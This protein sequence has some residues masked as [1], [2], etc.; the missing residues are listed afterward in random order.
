LLGQGLLAA[1]IARRLGISPRTV[2]KHLENIYRKLSVRDRLTAVA[3]A[4]SSGI[5][6]RRRTSRPRA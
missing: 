4:Q 3:V 1:T 5:V 2:N 6:P